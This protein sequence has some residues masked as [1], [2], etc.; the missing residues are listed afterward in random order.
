M[1]LAGSDQDP[2]LVSWVPYS[3]CARSGEHLILHFGHQ[4]VLDI[5][6]THA[7]DLAARTCWGVG[8]AMACARADPASGDI[9]VEVIFHAWDAARTPPAAEQEQVPR[10]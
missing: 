7:R 4:T 6:A 1:R 8:P 3:W 10:A 9:V 2:E 5:I